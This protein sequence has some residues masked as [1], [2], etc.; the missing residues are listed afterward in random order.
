MLTFL[1]FLDALATTSLTS[2]SWFDSARS[3]VKVNILYA[4]IH[5]YRNPS[6]SSS[7]SDSAAS[8][9]I[10]TVECLARLDLVA[11]SCKT[12]GYIGRAHTYCPL[13]R[14]SRGII[15]YLCRLQD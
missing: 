15:A 8:F 13:G 1:L 5:V 10:A 2:S 12:I 6:S 11:M 4:E 3:I 14:H 9:A 7:R